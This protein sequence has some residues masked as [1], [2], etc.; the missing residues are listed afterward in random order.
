MRYD[1]SKLIEYGI[2]T[3]NTTHRIHVDFEN[4]KIFVFLT[5]DALSILPGLIKPIAPGDWEDAGYYLVSPRWLQG[6]QVG[7]AT[8]RGIRIKSANIPRCREVSFLPRNTNSYNTSQKGHC[9]V[10]TVVSAFAAGDIPLHLKA[11]EVVGKSDQIKGR[12]LFTDDIL[13]QV[14]HDSGC[15]KRGLFFQTHEWNPNS[16]Y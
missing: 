9:A 7:K 8:A 6:D 4:G 10:S 3:E 14:K 1:I 11:L 13:I 12:D 5:S 15:A 2:H 16:C